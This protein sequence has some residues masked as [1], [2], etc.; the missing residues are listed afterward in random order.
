M[1]GMTRIR[2]LITLCLAAF[3]LA[4]V[5]PQAQASYWTAN[6]GLLTA[7]FTSG[8]SAWWTHYGLWACPNVAIQP[9]VY[10][11]DDLGNAPDGNPILGLTGYN[12][13]WT[14]I[15]SQWYLTQRNVELPKGGTAKRNALYRICEVATHETGHRYGVGQHDGGTTMPMRAGSYADAIGWSWCDQFVSEQ[16]STPI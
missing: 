2:S 10:L 4:A 14:K 1:P 7:A 12:S 9:T 5:A 13:C 16:G 3:T 8:Q 15:A 6:D 11:A